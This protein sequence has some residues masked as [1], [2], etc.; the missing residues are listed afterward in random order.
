MTRLEVNTIGL[1]DIVTKCF[2]PLQN[3]LD[4]KCMIIFSRM[5]SNVYLLK[6]CI[7]TDALHLEV[8]LKECL[9]IFL[10]KIQIL[11]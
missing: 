9:K 11:I 1:E 3:R 6:L 5:I 7:K 2:Y 4:F 8:N 10:K